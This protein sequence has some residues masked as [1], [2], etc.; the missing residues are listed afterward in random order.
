V[1]FGIELGTLELYTNHELNADLNRSA[2]E[3]YFYL[4]IYLFADAL[5]NL[6]SEIFN[7]KVINGS[8]V[9]ERGSGLI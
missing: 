8:D 5:N 4:F 7:G 2:L 9:E 6:N 1:T 3:I